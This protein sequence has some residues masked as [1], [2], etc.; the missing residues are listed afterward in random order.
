VRRAGGPGRRAG[1]QTTLASGE[2]TSWGAIFVRLFPFVDDVVYTCH[3][4][5]V[6]H[7]LGASGFST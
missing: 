2:G 4:G 5:G 6:G 1:T 3:G 7:A